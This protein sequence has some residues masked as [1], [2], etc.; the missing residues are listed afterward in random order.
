MH[1]ILLTLLLLSISSAEEGKPST[2]AEKI[3]SMNWLAGEWSGPMWGGTF[4][5]QYTS[6]EGGLVLSTSKLLQGG[7]AVYFE[8]ERFSVEGDDVVLTAYPKGKPAPSFRL[9]ALEEGKATFENPKKDFPTRIVYHRAG[10]KSLQITLS[11]ASGK[12][13]LFDLKR[14]D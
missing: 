2:P 10:E 7:K 14:P 12:S 6:P 11:D 4:V 1:R 3:A 9:T 8:F 5:T 13:E